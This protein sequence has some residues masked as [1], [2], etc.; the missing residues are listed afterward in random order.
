MG[1]V[2]LGIAARD[3]GLDQIG[4][5]M[6]HQ[7]ICGANELA[8]FGSDQRLLAIRDLLEYGSRPGERMRRFD[9]RGVSQAIRH[10]AQFGG[11]A[12]RMCRRY[13]Q[14]V[15]RRERSELALV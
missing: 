4:T 8:L 5:A 7:P 6:L 3:V 10:G 2:V 15:P 13:R 1:L 14:A 11:I 12:R 9:D